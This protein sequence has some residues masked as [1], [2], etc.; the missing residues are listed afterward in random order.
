MILTAEIE[1]DSKQQERRK[2]LQ[3]NN[4]RKTLV[5]LLYC[6]A[7]ELGNYPEIRI[8]GVRTTTTN[9]FKPIINSK[10]LVWQ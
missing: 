4:P 2:A 1:P 9:S 7:P 8:V 6:Q 10:P 3:K 5:S